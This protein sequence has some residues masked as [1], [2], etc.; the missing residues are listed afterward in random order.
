[1]YRSDKSRTRETGGTGLGLS[2]AKWIIMK[3]RGQISVSSAHNKGTK[4]RISFSG[5]IN[6]SRN[7]DTNK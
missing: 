1:F 4:I 2:I 6:Q 3:H 5:D 7:T